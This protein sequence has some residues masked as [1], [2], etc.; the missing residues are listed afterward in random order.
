M[1]EPGAQAG[2]TDKPPG[3]TPLKA[4]DGQP[5]ERSTLKKR[6]RSKRVGKIARGEPTKDSKRTNRIRI[7]LTL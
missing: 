6:P 1:F 4:P 7:Y 2:T 5:A 3:K